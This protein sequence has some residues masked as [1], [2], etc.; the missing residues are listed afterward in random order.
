MR[1]YNTRAVQ[2]SVLLLHEPPRC[3]LQLSVCLQALSSQQ[4]YV[5]L[6]SLLQSL[7]HFSNAQIKHQIRAYFA[8]H[9]AY[10]RPL[11]TDDYTR[12]CYNQGLR[13]PVVRQHS[14]KKS[15]YSISVTGCINYYMYCNKTFPKEPRG[16]KLCIQIM[17]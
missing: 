10:K 2:F 16:Y 7:F 4:F 13:P 17:S 5:H 8:V 6:C 3:W 14:C 9:S 1:D 12:T 11:I 15:H